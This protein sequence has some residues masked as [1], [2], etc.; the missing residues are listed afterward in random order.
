MVSGLFA[1]KVAQAEASAGGVYF[2]A[3]IYPILQIDKVLA[4]QSRK[5]EDLA[6]VECDILDSRVPSRPTGSRASWVV[7]FKHDSAPRDFKAFLSAAAGVPP[8]KVDAAGVNASVSS[9]NPLHGRLIALEV[10]LVDTK[11]G[12][13]FSRHFWRSIPESEQAFA[14]S[15][16]TAAGLPPF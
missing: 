15:K 4:K 16:R 2:D 7:N 6:I 5:G 14:S 12:G 3:G 9:S 10:V 13:K 1:D 11:K 8:E